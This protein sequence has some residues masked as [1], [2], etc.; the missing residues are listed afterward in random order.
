MSYK[1]YLK[2]YNENIIDESLRDK[3]KTGLAKTK[4]KLK[5]FMDTLDEPV[6]QDYVM[7]ATKGGN[8]YEITTTGGD[9]Y[10]LENI[11]Q[12]LEPFTYEDE[13]GNNDEYIFVNADKSSHSIPESKLKSL[14]K[15]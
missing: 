1:Q 8:T 4:T 13:Q 9:T 15:L 14:R 6:E 11:I 2:E 10:K 12:V 3:I 7:P 5:K